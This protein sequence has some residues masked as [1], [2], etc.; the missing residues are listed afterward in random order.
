LFVG[1]SQYE[2]LFNHT[3]M[4][5]SW[6]LLGVI[7]GIIASWVVDPTLAFSMKNKEIYGIKGS[8]WTSPQWNWGY[9]RGTGH[10][11]AAIC[12]EL[13]HTREA[14]TKLVNNLMAANPDEPENVEEIKLIL[15]LEW[16]R[17]K[18]DGSDGGKG[19]YGQVLANMAA[20]TRYE[21][22]GG[23]RRLV[24]DMADPKRFS[25]LMASEEDIERIKSC[26]TENT[27]EEGFRKCS[28][29]V[30]RAMGFVERGL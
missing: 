10:D 13:Y 14:R 27:L 7:F 24:E 3:P 11:C 18:W 12:R 28:G 29:M 25:L 30:L 15:A 6:L 20:A 5:T 2:W 26:V 4:L 9:S 16:Q 1:A 19:G 23:L 8:G 21:D 22:D 17:G